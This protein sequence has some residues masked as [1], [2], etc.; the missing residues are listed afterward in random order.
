MV[1]QR[2]LGANRENAKKSTGPRT[3]AGQKRASRNSFRHGLSVPL[4]SADFIK[5][6]DKL[7][8]RIAGKDAGAIVLNIAYSI[9]EAHLELVRVRQ[10]KTAA[11]N[12]IHGYG[13]L[14]SSLPVDPDFVAKLSR[15]IETAGL[16]KELGYLIPPLLPPMPEREPERTAEAM[17]RAI[18]KL[19]KLDRYEDRALARRTRAIEQLFQ[20]NNTSTQRKLQNE[21]KLG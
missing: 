7:A 2:R 6:L 20:Y 11:I 12:Y 8:R 3:T 19:V 13:A 21:A 9:A 4:R 5:R 17:R 16:I 18:P 10:T 15:L 14:R 1:S